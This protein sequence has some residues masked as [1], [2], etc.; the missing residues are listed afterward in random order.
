MAAS[1]SIQAQID[2]LN[3]HLETYTNVVIP[4]EVESEL[5]FPGEARDDERP[6]RFK[7]IKSPND[8]AEL[9][10]LLSEAAD[11]EEPWNYEGWLN[12]EADGAVK[13]VA[14]QRVGEDKP[15]GFVVFSGLFDLHVFNGDEIERATTI[16]D[17]EASFYL[18]VSV[19]SVYISPGERG[20]GF[21]QALSWMVGNHA[22]EMLRFLE[23]NLPEEYQQ[24]IKLREV[25]VLVEGEAHSPGG[26]R[27]LSRAV[28]ELEAG[29]EFLGFGEQSWFP[30]VQV[31]NGIDFSDFPDRGWSAAVVGYGG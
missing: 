14:V 18:T 17:V 15:A 13:I 23:G 11:I 2:R 3:A 22:D 1:N 9:A 10:A 27:F 6:Y 30:I 16:D 25:T 8:M 20:K 7:E 4:A 5:I 24:Q 21:S 31:S 12:V 19:D 29:V 28:E 26:A